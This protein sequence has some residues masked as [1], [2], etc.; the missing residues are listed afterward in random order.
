MRVVFVVASRLGDGTFWYALM[1][2]IAVW[3]DEKAPSAVLH[4]VAAGVACTILYKSLKHGTAR[5]RP[6]V[7][8]ADITLFTAPLDK[9]SFPSGHTLH[10]VAF[11]LIAAGYY[12]ALFWLLGPFCVLVALSRVVLGLHYPSDVIAGA[13]MGAA[14]AML[15]EVL[16]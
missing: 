6:Y 4:M 7:A 16:L 9:Y 14:V 13:G 15:S 8:Q 2:A 3:E 1:A 5:A 11:T 10:A 12:P